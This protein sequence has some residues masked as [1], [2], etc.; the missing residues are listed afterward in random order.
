MG[1]EERWEGRTG[2]QYFSICF[3]VA[4]SA[5]QRL[6]LYWLASGPKQDWLRWMSQGLT[7]RIVWDGMGWVSGCRA[8]EVCCGNE[9]GKMTYA[10]SKMVAC[11]CEALFWDYAR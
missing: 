9:W 10:V 6:G 11:D 1:R 8:F 3:T 5:S 7:L 2:I 4:G